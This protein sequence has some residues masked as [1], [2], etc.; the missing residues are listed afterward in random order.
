MLSPN[1]LTDGVTKVPKG[2]RTG[3]WHFCHLITLEV[4]EKHTTAYAT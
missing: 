4:F 2:C 1:T 3:F